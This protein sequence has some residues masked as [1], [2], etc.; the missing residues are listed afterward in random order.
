MGWT[1]RQFQWFLLQKYLLLYLG[2]TC[3]GF[4]ASALQANNSS[5]HLASPSGISSEEMMEDVEFILHLA[6]RKGHLEEKITSSVSG[7]WREQGRQEGGLW[8]CNSTLTDS[9]SFCL[10]LWNTLVLGLKHVQKGWVGLGGDLA[11]LGHA[12]SPSSCAS[13]ST[14]EITHS[15]DLQN[16]PASYLLSSLLQTLRN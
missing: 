5:I 16:N 15:P 11:M 2:C 7:P 9:H 4:Q 6:C 1:P 10:C 13:H 8:L 12:L 3:L 14:R